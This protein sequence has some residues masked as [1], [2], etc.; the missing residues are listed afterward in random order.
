MTVLH[1]AASAL[2]TGGGTGIGRHIAERLVRDGYQVTIVG[3]R[4]GPLRST[5]AALGDSVSIAIA[6]VT[7]E[8]E[9]ALA[10]QQ[11]DARAPLKVAILAAGTG[12]AYS[13]V[14]STPL[15]AWRRVLATNLDGAFIT[16]RSS[17][18]TI[19]KNGGG[20]IVAVSSIAAV[21]PHPGMSPYAVSKAGLEALI[22][23]GANELGRDGVRVNAIR[24]GVVES[25]MTSGLYRDDAFAV[26]QLD[27]TPLGRLGSA[28]DL[29]EA[30]SFLVSPQ[31]SWVTGVCL[32]VDGG[33][34]LR[35]MIATGQP[36]LAR[37]IEDAAA[38]LTRDT[39]G[40]SLLA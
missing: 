34:H 24:A 3:R 19:A 27:E 23:N 36:G 15:R 7:S 25:D 35:G 2:V 17:A 29:A 20:S 38:R 33:N 37:G 39:D 13:E 1:T 26:R 32:P 12:S 9:V 22:T 31:A 11:A 40:G 5:Q 28:V 30:V 8:S 16:L 4:E 6:N 10:V 21:K 14:T 18:I